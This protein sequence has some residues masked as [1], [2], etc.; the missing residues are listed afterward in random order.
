MMLKYGEGGWDERGMKDKFTSVRCSLRHWAPCLNL[1]LRSMLCSTTLWGQSTT[2]LPSFYSVGTERTTK[3][4]QHDLLN[5]VRA[6]TPVKGSSIPCK[7]L[8]ASNHVVSW[9]ISQSKK[10]IKRRKSERPWEL[11]EL[12][13]TTLTDGDVKKAT[14]IYFLSYIVVQ[15]WMRWDDLTEEGQRKQFGG[16]EG[17]E[18]EEGACVGQGG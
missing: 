11:I 18:W 8:L 1:Q 6:P 15:I 9:H 4:S 7:K 17:G 14:N 13:T 2:F 3:A 5:L 12:P 10:T 16:V